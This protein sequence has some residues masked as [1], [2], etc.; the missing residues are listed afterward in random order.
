MAV[1]IQ[2]SFEHGGYNFLSECWESNLNQ[3]VDRRRALR[4][5]AR[6]SVTFEFHGDEGGWG[7]G[8]LRDMLAIWKAESGVRAGTRAAS[9]GYPVRHGYPDG[10][11]TVA[12]AN[13]PGGA[14]GHAW[15]W[16]R[17]TAAGAV[18]G[19]LPFAEIF[20]A[21][22]WLDVS[23]WNSQVASGERE[24]LQALLLH[25][26]GHALGLAHSC[27]AD[28]RRC[29]DV[30]Q[31]AIMNWATRDLRGAHLRNYDRGA[32]RTLY[33]VDKS[34]PEPDPDPEPPP[35]DT[36]SGFW[37]TTTNGSSFSVDYFHEGAWKKAEIGVRSGDSAVFHFFCPDNLEVFAKVLNACAIDGSYWV[38]ASG[39]TDL[40]LRL[41][42][43]RF[44]GEALELFPVPDGTVLRPNN[45][46]RLRWCR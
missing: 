36:P 40:P 13:L 37:H 18:G 46:G 5:P 17:C 9:N 28:E 32:I 35:P 38:Y 24:Q 45:G 26:I 8:Y 6:S 14:I 39:L 43:R 44:A 33:P 29:S 19:T 41:Q 21:D 10:R 23:W 42:V 15:V 22:I 27:E 16:A 25:E 34:E 11:N 3:W 4:W 7:R 2:G 1:A 30:K 20:E 12:F 31:A